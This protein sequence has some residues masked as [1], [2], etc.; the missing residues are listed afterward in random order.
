MH[1]NIIHLPAILGRLFLFISLVLV[2]S[3]GGDNSNVPR[4]TNNQQDRREDMEVEL[5]NRPQAQAIVLDGASQPSTSHSNWLIPYDGSIQNVQS[6]LST[7]NILSPTALGSDNNSKRKRNEQG[8]QVEK[9]KKPKKKVKKEKEQEEVLKKRKKSSGR[10]NKETQNYLKKRAKKEKEKEGAVVEEKGATDELSLDKFLHDE[11]IAE[12]FSHVG[13]PDIVKCMLVNKH[14]YDIIRAKANY[15]GQ[16]INF[17]DKALN[18]HYKLP[19][20][21]QDH[22]IERN[23]AFKFFTKKVKNLPLY[24]LYSLAR[25]Q[26]KEFD[27]SMV[28]DKGIAIRLNDFQVG[29]LVNGLKCFC[30]NVTSLNLAGN[31]LTSAGITELLKVLPGLS[32]LEVLDLSGT[33][34]EGVGIHVLMTVLKNLNLKKFSLATNG[35]SEQRLLV[36]PP[37]W[38]LPTLSS[39]EY[40]DLSHN[41]NLQGG[42]VKILAACPNLKRI[43]L[44]DTGL[45]GNEVKDL[46]NVLDLS[47]VEELVLLENPLDTNE[48]IIALCEGLQEIPDLNL[49]QLFLPSMELDSPEMRALVKMLPHLS[50]LERIDYWS[51]YSSIGSIKDKEISQLLGKNLRKLPNLK[52]LCLTTSDLSD[53]LIVSMVESFLDHSDKDLPEILNLK[54][55]KLNISGL[56]FGLEGA[57]AFAKILPYF[58]CLKNI[59]LS[60][61]GLNDEGITILVDA[62][63]L[64]NVQKLHLDHNQLGLEGAEALAKILPHLSKLRKLDLSFT[65]LTEEAVSKILNS[66]G[67]RKIKI[68]WIAFN[69]S[70]EDKDRIKQNSPNVEWDFGR[71]RGVSIIDTSVS[72]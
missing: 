70:V 5:G 43:N 9:K 51:E 62:L 23:L 47:K 46:L 61:N 52:V 7:P 32:K 33:L 4:F 22:D 49:R 38:A 21:A 26:V 71:S 6:L 55:E 40:L 35:L 63:K 10:K 13:F 11:I 31:R 28:M 15:I 67:G 36:L 50:N 20:N 42:V 58:P 8:E 66:L 65:D 12:I 44:A 64:S 34:V 17:K 2:A 39:L 45:C 59:D 56:G 27:W 18:F 72:Y 60:G 30:P 69:L 68:C 24:L 48:G 19:W 29:M 57:K 37:T 3:C 14:W 16:S 41:S 54:L 53:E 25:T 1:A